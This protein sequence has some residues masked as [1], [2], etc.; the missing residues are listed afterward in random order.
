MG[1][2]LESVKE[3]ITNIFFKQKIDELLLFVS[4]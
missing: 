3:K 4:S 2:S 1:T